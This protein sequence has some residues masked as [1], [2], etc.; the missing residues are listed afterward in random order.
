MPKIGSK[1]SSQ[2]DRLKMA[3]GHFTRRLLEQLHAIGI[4]HS[5]LK[6]LG[7]IGASC[8]GPQEAWKAALEHVSDGKIS[9]EKIDRYM[10]YG[11]R[12]RAPTRSGLQYLE[13]MVS[14]VM[15]RP[16][17]TVVIY[18]AT[19]IQA[20]CSLLD[21]IQPLTDYKRWPK[22]TDEWHLKLDYEPTPDQVAYE[23]EIRQKRV[24]QLQKTRSVA[25][26]AG[27]LAD[28]HQRVD[29]EIRDTMFT[30]WNLLEKCVLQ[31]YQG[32]AVGEGAKLKKPSKQRFISIRYEGG[33]PSLHEDIFSRLDVAARHFGF[34]SI[35]SHRRST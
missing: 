17:Q 8:Y 19:R 32:S 12:H 21:T 3:L 24:A 25:E 7:V 14:L 34:R 9:R 23:Q 5:R 29:E 18:D 20:S 13:N 33:K 35:A 15:K 2:G 10:A 31:T 26:Q 30:K 28:W 1:H 11:R 16:A 4:S 22:T 6:E 27:W